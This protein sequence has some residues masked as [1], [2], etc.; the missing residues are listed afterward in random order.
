MS[1]SPKSEYSKI[2][3]D[4]YGGG[5]E[6]SRLSEIQLYDKSPKL[7]IP[8][9][10]KSKEMEL[11]NMINQQQKIN[12]KLKKDS[13]NREIKKIEYISQKENI[14]QFHP[15]EQKMYH[16]HNNKG[17]KNQQEFWIKQVEQ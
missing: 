17:V 12:P 14:N 13:V 1:C 9:G 10:P 3:E 11:L 2:E 15:L 7:G 8:I 5:L 16:M 4:V 6:D